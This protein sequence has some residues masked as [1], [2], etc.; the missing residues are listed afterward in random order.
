MQKIYY[1]EQ[2]KKALK[3]FP[4]DVYKVHREFIIALV[5]IK[6]AAAAGNFLAGNIS[7]DVKAAITKAC[8]EILAGKHKEQ[9]LLPA[10]QGGAGTST[11]M[12]VNEVV[13]ARA[14]EILQSQGKKTVVHPNDHVNR[15]MS[16]NDANPSAIKI[17]SIAL[18]QNLQKTLQFLVVV[19][20][21]KAKSFKGVPKLARTHLQDAIPT[22]LGAE[23][24]SYADI[25]RWHQEKINRVVVYCQELNLGGSAIG[26]SLNASPKYIAGTYKELNRITGQKFHPAKN[27]MSQTSSQTDFLAISQAVT[28]L[29][30]DCSKIASDLRL[31]ASGPRGG[32]GEIQLQELQN[33]SS[34]M[35]GKVNPIL[36]EAVNQLYYMVSG[37]NL[38]IEH[39]AH[40]AQL[41]LGVMF[42]IIADRLLQT[43]KISSQVLAKFTKDAVARIK[44]NKARCRELL[45][46]STAYAT[47]L[48]PKLGYDVMAQTVKESVSSGKTFREVLVGK[49]LLTNKEFDALTKIGK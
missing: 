39:S 2:T 15:S 7:R 18:T 9:F 31:M 5:Q 42:P 8:D 11:N 26:N 21:Q 38:T 44:A 6:K 24:Q 34:I 33:G 47:I 27:L 32:L 35:P 48:T 19:L 4:F 17:A 16:T 1:G 45:E 22:T 43:L 41:E 12:N 23:F 3:N 29:C 14:T 46:R 49:K 10:L 37:N 36:P 25:I 20:E 40:G 13:A 30:L 28:A